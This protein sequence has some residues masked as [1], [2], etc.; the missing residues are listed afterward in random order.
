MYHLVIYINSTWYNER[1]S[2]T[3]LIVGGSPTDRNSKA[4]SYFSGLLPHPDF[5]IVAP[6]PS[7]GIEEVRTLEHQIFLRP[8]S[9]KEKVIHIRE[10]QFLTPEA[11]N[12]LLKTLEEPPA[13]ITI[14]LSAPSE[15]YL[16]QTVISRCQVIKLP[17]KPQT[18]S[19]ED[20]EKMSLLLSIPKKSLGEGF[21]FLAKLTPTK[22]SAIS[23]IE[24]NQRLL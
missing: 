24:E 6:N 21:E 14:I 4:E 13:H 7:I 2:R 1:M 22:E 16:L 19:N 3:I 5:L 17:L 18:L 9:E 10:A 23:W 8:Y 20:T 15:T 12:A 11:Q